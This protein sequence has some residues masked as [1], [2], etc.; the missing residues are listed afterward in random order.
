M[1]LVDFQKSPGS[2]VGLNRQANGQKNR[3]ARVIC[4]GNEK[5]GSGKSTT[6]MH[7]TVALMKM[8]QKVGA[9]DLDCRQKSFSRYIHNRTR[10]AEKKKRDIQVPTLKPVDRSAQEMRTRAELE[11]KSQFDAALSELCTT[12]DY[13]VIDSPGSDTYLSRLGHASA[14]T[15]ITPIN[16]SFIDLDLIAD[17]DPETNEVIGPSLYSEMVWDSRKKRALADRVSIDWILMRNRLSSLD[18]KNKRKMA[19]ALE[20]LSPRTGF[21]I[22]PGFGER[23]IY[24]EL[25]PL[26]LTLLDVEEAGA[27]ITFS[28]SHV[29]ARQELRDLM[30][31]LK[32]PGLEQVAAS[33]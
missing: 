4:L 26:G 17:I 15:I 18:A 1:S 6:A 12:C 8:G 3:G 28:M 20:K 2:V 14:D 11:E 19:D 5:G 23:V 10:W 32:L 16:D 13:V 9:I 33:F 7:I 24:R 25:F 22:A 21:R 31:T 30:V 27:D 29:A